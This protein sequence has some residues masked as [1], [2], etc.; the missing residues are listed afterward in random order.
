MI[1]SQPIQKQSLQKM[2]RETLRQAILEREIEPGEQINI[3][4]LA[5]KLAVSTM[6]VREALREL[7]AEGMISFQSNKRIL[8]SQLSQE[9]L[10]DIYDIRIP[11][12][13]I[14]LLKC[15]ERNDKSGLRRLEELHRQMDKPGV[16]GGEWFNLNRAFHMKMHEMSGSARLFQILQGLWNSTGPYLRLFSDHAKAVSQANSEHAQILDS[17]RRHDALLAKKVLKSHLRNGL[18]TI[19]AALGAE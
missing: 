10:N 12:E 2:V 15:L 18:K 19:A 13:E 11:L 14:A 9:D 8:A 16:I 7:E 6:P 1:L 4:K 3:R 5:E 17:I